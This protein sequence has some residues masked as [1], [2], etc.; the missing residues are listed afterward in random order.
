MSHLNK[1]G[2]TPLKR[3]FFSFLWPFPLQKQAT[4]I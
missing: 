1:D 3:S 4:H 2:T